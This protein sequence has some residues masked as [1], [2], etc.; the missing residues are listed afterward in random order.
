MAYYEQQCTREMREVYGAMLRSVAAVE[1]AIRIPMLSMEALGEVYTRLRLD[2]PEIFYLTGFHVRHMPEAAYG[3][4]IPEYLFDKGKI[5]SHRQAIAT[6]VERLTREVKGKSEEERIQFLHRFVVENVRY[7]KLKKAYSHEAIGPLTQGVG[8]CEG[9][10]K[11][12]KLLADALQIDCIVA[13][14]AAEEGKKYGH[15]WNVVKKGGKW[16]HMDCTFDL[17]LSQCGEARWDYFLLNDTQIFRDH[18]KSV[19][20][21]PECG[22]GNAFY[23]KTQ[24]LSFTKPEDLTRRITQAAKKKKP[25]FIFHWRGGYL[26]R[27]MLT[28]LMRWIGAAAEEAGKGV[29]LSLNWPQAVFCL[30][31]SDTPVES[32]ILTMERANEADE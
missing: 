4:L 25:R 22:D 29:S 23:Y 16:Y 1:S 10:A 28:E 20:P 7:D 26:T 9:I 24:K 21:I 15:A 6:R 30:S 17:T 5:L 14:S 3:E 32:Q 12:V 2:H 8:V 13:L 11:T 18:V 27:E 19:Y 31:F